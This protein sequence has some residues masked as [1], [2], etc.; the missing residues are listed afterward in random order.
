MIY[1]TFYKQLIKFVVALYMGY[2]I[3]LYYKSCSSFCCKKIR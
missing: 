2:I 1:I 3:P